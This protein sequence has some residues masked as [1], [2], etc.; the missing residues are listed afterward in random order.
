MGRD[1]TFSA[2]TANTNF[3]AVLVIVLTVLAM[4]YTTVKN[5]PT[6]M[7]DTNGLIQQELQNPSDALSQ[8]LFFV[9]LGLIVI[10]C[11]LLLVMN[12][13]F[14]IIRNKTLLPCLFYTLFL[15]TDTDIFFSFSGNVVTLVIVL[16]FFQLFKFYQ[17][18][19]TNE[20]A[21]NIGFIVAIGSLLAPRI[22]LFVP[23]IWIGFSFFK[24]NSIKVY[25]ASIMGILTP[26]WLVFFWL[27][28]KGNLQDFLTPF[29][30]LFGYNPGTVLHFETSGWIRMIFTVFITILAIINFQLHNFMDK[31]RSRIIF[32]FLFTIMV[33]VGILLSLGIVPL[34]EYGGIYF[35]IAAL[36]A[37]HYFS[38]ANS[39]IN[40][41]F[42]YLVL[43]TYVGL[44]F[45]K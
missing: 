45:F 41:I 39:R 33:I 26:Y 27:V 2:K 11:I 25:L 19:R 24:V 1:K 23:V 28:Y 43:I 32:Y 44:I 7:L 9:N 29:Q 13:S 3:T 31:I 4:L 6:I 12:N 36:F 8:A 18:T 35:L 10:T 15:V 34:N 17:K 40:T 22:L 14:S 30:N 20:E 21:F 38:T 16:V 5:Y 37:S 42:F